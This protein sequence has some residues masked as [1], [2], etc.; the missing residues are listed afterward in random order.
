MMWYDA[1][2]DTFSE[3]IEI[4]EDR[5]GPDVLRILG[6]FVDLEIELEPVPQDEDEFELWAQGQNVHAINGP[7]RGWDLDLREYVGSFTHIICLDG[8]KV[9]YGRFSDD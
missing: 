6:P 1:R 4:L 5:Y 7:R 3:R 8:E 2:M 9:A